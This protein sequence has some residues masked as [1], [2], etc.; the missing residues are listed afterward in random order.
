LLPL[1]AVGGLLFANNS[2]GSGRLAGW[3]MY[4]VCRLLL[5]VALKI[6][7]ATA[8]RGKQK[9]LAEFDY[10]DGLL[11][12]QQQQQQQQ[13]GGVSTIGAAGGGRPNKLPFY[14]TGSDLSVAGASPL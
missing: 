8:A 1:P 9:L 7:A 11:Q 3:V 14:L 13:S 4:Y 12:Q 5:P 6:N 10:L 2:G